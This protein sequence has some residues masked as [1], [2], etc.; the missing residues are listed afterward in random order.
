MQRPEP[1][2]QCFTEL[3][4]GSQLP[5]ITVHTHSLQNNSPVIYIDL[6]PATPPK[7]QLYSVPEIVVVHKD[8]TIHRVPCDF[9]RAGR[10]YRA[11]KPDNEISLPP[12]VLS[13]QWFSYEEASTRIFAHQ[14]EV[15][16]SFSA[17][18][19]S[20]L[21]VFYREIRHGNPSLRL[22]TFQLDPL[23][24]ADEISTS[25]NQQLRP[26]SDSSLPSAHFDTSTSTIRFHTSSAPSTLSISSANMFLM[27]HLSA[28]V[29]RLCSR[30]TL[31][32]G[33]SSLFPLGS[34]FL[35]GAMASVIRIY[36]VTYQSIR[37][38]CGLVDPSK[39]HAS[40]K[41]DKPI[42]IVSYFPKIETL[43]AVKGR[44]L[45][46]INLPRKV[47]RRSLQTQSQPLLVD[48]LGCNTF[49]SDKV[50]GMDGIK[51]GR[52]LH[53]TL[54]TSSE[55]DNAGW[56]KKQ[57][58]LDCLVSQGRIAEFESIAASELSSRAGGDVL[59]NQVEPKRFP[60]RQHFVGQGKILYILSKIF[61]V[62]TSIS[63]NMSGKKN[64][65]LKMVFL[66]AQLF[67]WLAQNSH[68]TAFNVEQ[69][70]STADARVALKGGAIARC[71][72]EQDG[73][74][75]LLD[76][77]MKGDNLVSVDEH[78]QLIQ[79]L[80]RVI[81]TTSVVDPPPQQLLLENSCPSPNVTSSALNE[82]INVDEPRSGSA[83]SE[84]TRDQHQILQKAVRKLQPYSS[85]AIS[86]AIRNHFTTDETLG[87]VQ[88]LRQQLF[89]SGHTGSVGRTE[90]G[91][92]EQA[93]SLA[94]LT[95]VLSSCVDS[96]GPLKFLDPNIDE[97]LWQSVV[98]DLSSEISV[99][100]GGIE[101]AS[102]L[103]GV[104]QEMIRHSKS[105]SRREVAISTL[106][107]SPTPARTS[108]AAAM[109]HGASIETVVREQKDQ[110]MGRVAQPACLLPLAL[111][112]T[113]RMSSL[114]RREIDEGRSKRSTRELRYLEEQNVGQYSF[115]RLRI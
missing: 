91:S 105:A 43:L 56:M 28:D 8:G 101:E 60:P 72:I 66:P 69:A 65:D 81:L 88:F 12:E 46:A 93:L 86:T 95:C 73:S 77:Y 103:K 76:A 20:F 26:V 53:K 74:L 2:L 68:L 100:L 64:A 79:L 27:Y 97:G 52:G 21:F 54:Y 7:E 85:R 111:N 75:D 48:S 16:K 3:L 67:R 87:L 6:I 23:L 35:A 33:H 90:S 25:S 30:L 39:W 58:H 47:I 15:L 49:H 98:P 41:P 96:L 70:I 109:D 45:F 94:L 29:P 63:N 34:K 42:R 106:Q 51:L 110:Q 112:D 9:E 115:E 108:A 62:S 71:V 10:T 59:Q 78:V 99:A 5:A 17:S 18:G 19:S 31:E 13:A 24:P 114:K 37:T 50:K 1:Q 44:N 84:R 80:L 92:D 82:K 55:L 57:T 61:C 107:K 83:L 11:L 36:D 104:L 89:Y 32:D 22:G 38:S 102:Y 14:N 40:E 4:S 113:N